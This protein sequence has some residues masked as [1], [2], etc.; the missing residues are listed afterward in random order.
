MSNIKIILISVILTI[1][2]ITDFGCWLQSSSMEQ[3]LKIIFCLVP[4]AFLLFYS[5]ALTV[6]LMPFILPLISILRKE[7]NEECILIQAFPVTL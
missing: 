6:T 2:V 5:F 4:F 3:M 7:I 1:C